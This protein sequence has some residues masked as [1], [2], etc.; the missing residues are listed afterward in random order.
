ML[1]VE[2]VAPFTSVDVASFAGCPFVDGAVG[3]GTNTVTVTITVLGAPPGIVD[4]GT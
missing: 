1:L 3:A 2:V 4:P